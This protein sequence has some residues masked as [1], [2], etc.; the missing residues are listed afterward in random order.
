VLRY[1]HFLIPL[2]IFRIGKFL[3]LKKS[4]QPQRF[5]KSLFDELR[6]PQKML[7]FEKQGKWLRIGYRMLHKTR[8]LGL[9]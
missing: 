6:L 8:K 1:E 5:K 4:N 2:Y 3:N 7:P 9:H